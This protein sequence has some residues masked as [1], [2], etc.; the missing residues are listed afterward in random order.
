M[1][2]KEYLPF[3]LGQQCQTDDG[4]IGRF[5]GFDICTTDY[6]I[7]MITV[8]F[9][10]EDDEDFAVYNDNEKC[11]RIKLILRELSSMT[12]EEMKELYKLMDEPGNTFHYPVTNIKF[13]EK[14]DGHQPNIINV[15][16]EG[17]NGSSGGIGHHT[18]LLNRIN[19]RSFQYLISKGFDIF[20]LIPNNLAIKK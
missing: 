8:K 19:S 14:I 13:G 18:I 20:N 1:D 6:S 2:T 9:D 17:T 7:V 10:E 3:Y 5:S 11:D 12:E 4:K 16:F 15:K